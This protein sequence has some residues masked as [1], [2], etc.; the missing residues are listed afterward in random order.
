[1]KA[2]TSL[3]VSLVMLAGCAVGPS[4]L[5]APIDAAADANY[6]CRGAERTLS[7]TVQTLDRD[8]AYCAAPDGGYPER[9]E[10]T[11]TEECGGAG[12]CIDGLCV[13][14]GV[15]PEEID[16]GDGCYE[17]VS[18]RIAGLAVDGTTTVVAEGRGRTGRVTVA[19]EQSTTYVITSQSASGVRERRTVAVKVVPD[20]SEIP[21]PFEEPLAFQPPNCQPFNAPLTKDLARIFPTPLIGGSG[22]AIRQVTNASRYEIVVGTD[23]PIRG[24]VTMRPDE[25]TEELNGVLKGEWTVEPAAPVL[26]PTPPGDCTVA[27]GEPAEPVTL[28]LE[29][30]CLRDN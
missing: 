4:G 20:A 7:W 22:V 18:V 5:P 28:V 14:P 1:M 3:L 9:Q 21:P 26:S 13:M 19:P 17:D 2:L 8:R 12:S 27:G 10:C 29:L 24:P 6:T 30:V 23:D 11:L 16:R 25:M 15:D